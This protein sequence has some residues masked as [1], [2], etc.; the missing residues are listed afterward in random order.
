MV[1]KIHYRQELDMLRPVTRLAIYSTVVMLLVIPCMLIGATLAVVGDLRLAIDG[2]PQPTLKEQLFS[3]LGLST[4]T[5]VFDYAGTFLLVFGALAYVLWI[6]FHTY[7]EHVKHPEVHLILKERERKMR[8]R[9][10]TERL[11][12][13]RFWSRMWKRLLAPFRN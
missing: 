8:D 7:Y 11:A 10:E 9:I 3:H 6:M 4:D 13:K 1:E 5:F 2:Q 12:W